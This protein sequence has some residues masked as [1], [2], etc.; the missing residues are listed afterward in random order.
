M[1]QRTLLSVVLLLCFAW[2][3][4][5]QVT[6]SITTDGSVGAAGD[7]SFGDDGVALIPE[8]RGTQLGGNLV[9]WF[10]LLKHCESRHGRTF[11]RVGLRFRVVDHSI[12]LVANRISDRDRLFERQSVQK[13]P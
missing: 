7:I 10:R 8:D 12:V 1:L 11:R 2:P 3:S 6:G 9:S 5:A 4:M 13:R